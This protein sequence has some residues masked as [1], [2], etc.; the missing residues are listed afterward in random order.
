MDRAVID[1]IKSF[2]F[3]VWMHKPSDRYAY[4]TDGTR[5]G[6]IEVDHRVTTYRISTVHHPNRTTGTGFAMEEVYSI[7]KSVLESGFDIAPP[8]ASDRDIESV[9]KYHDIDDFVR[10]HNQRYL[11]LALSKVT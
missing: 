3:D 8:W 5:I 2:G 7:N 6:Y 10:Q 9:I 4:Y 11:F 1:L